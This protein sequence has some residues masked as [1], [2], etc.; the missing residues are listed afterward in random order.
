MNPSLLVE[1]SALL[2]RWEGLFSQ[3][4]STWKAQRHAWGM[5]LTM[6]TTQISRILCTLGLAGRDWSSEYRH[7]SR[8]NWNVQ[9]C[10]EPVI[11]AAVRLCPGPCIDVAGDF[12]HVRK[13]GRKIAGV[14]LMRDPA[15]PIKWHNNLILGTSYLQLAALVPAQARLADGSP[16]TASRCLPVH[17]SASPCPKKPSKRASTEE[18]QRYRQQ[19]QK[20]PAMNAAIEAVKDLRGRLDA[21]GAQDRTL[22]MVLDGSFANRCLLEQSIERTHITCR[23][24][25][26]A[27]LRLPAP[28]DQPCGFYAK[29]TLSPDSIRTDHASY[30]FKQA[31]IRLTNRVI[32]VR[33]KEVPLVYWPSAAG[34]RPLRL[35]LIAQPH[36]KAKGTPN[37]APCFDDKTYHLITTD[38]HRPA[39]QLIQAAF[40]RW[41]I[42]VVHREEKTVFG[43]GDAQVRN[44]QSVERHP[45]FAVA[46]YSLLH[47]A[48]LQ[49][50]RSHQQPSLPLPK[51]RKHQGRPSAQTLLNLLRT[52]IH[53][54]PHALAQWGINTPVEQIV[55]AAAA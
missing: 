37:Q 34:R 9:D 23:C 27:R 28:V 50:A 21:Q 36:H 42:E 55:Q 17:F 53:R 33:Y 47:L 41:Q 43:I 49:L 39:E 6:G 14:R 32:N 1:L 45:A 54:D 44:I 18:W 15:N 24:R 19:C 7:F 31:G 12:T 26:N 46:C 8:D 16:H 4:R 10:F 40:D 52:E 29:G 3:Y 35:I 30:P 2:A 5:M 51:W 20:R 48:A 13:S 11:E 38:L 25:K 22:S